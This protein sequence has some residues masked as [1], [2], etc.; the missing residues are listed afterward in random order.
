MRFFSKNLCAFKKLFHLAF[1][2]GFWHTG[3]LYSGEELKYV[4]SG[5]WQ[6]LHAYKQG[7]K[8]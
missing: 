4:V 7:K 3:T 6:Y 2:E 8:C 1:V 5:F